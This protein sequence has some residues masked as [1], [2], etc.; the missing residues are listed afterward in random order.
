MC[1]AQVPDCQDV[2]GN[3]VVVVVAA[4]Y[5]A[6][7]VQSEDLLVYLVQVTKALPSRCAMRLMVRCLLGQACPTVTDDSA[8]WHR[9]LSPSNAG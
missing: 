2:R 9:Q 8:A 7:T 3:L 1:T 6:Q 4:H 5:R